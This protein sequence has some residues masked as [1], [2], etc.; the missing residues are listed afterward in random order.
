[1]PNKR[2][3]AFDNNASVNKSSRK[4]A[5]KQNE[6]LALVRKSARL[7]ENNQKNIT[8][9]DKHIST[10]K[11]KKSVTK[12]KKTGKSKSQVDCFLVLRFY[13]G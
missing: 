6:D 4:I 12:P 7:M 3:P 5:E 10:G 2:K 13:S 11:G 1:M 9:P 8:N